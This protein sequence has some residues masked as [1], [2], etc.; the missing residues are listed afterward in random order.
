MFSESF[1]LLNKTN[2][3]EFKLIF[4][5]QLLGVY[6]LEKCHNQTSDLVAAN[7]FLRDYCHLLK[8]HLNLVTAV[9]S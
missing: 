4:N 2:L 1:R 8:I 9:K 3:V 5:I 6:A 7:L